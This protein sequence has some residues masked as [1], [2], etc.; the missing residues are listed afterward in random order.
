MQTTPQPMQRRPSQWSSLQ[1]TGYGLRA[2]GY[3][4][5]CVLDHQE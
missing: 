1:A 2:T 4:L 3:G 5:V